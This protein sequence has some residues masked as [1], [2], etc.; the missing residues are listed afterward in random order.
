MIRQTT[1]RLFIT[2]TARGRNAWRTSGNQEWR[3]AKIQDPPYTDTLFNAKEV[4]PDSR[5]I[6][7]SLVNVCIFMLV[8]KDGLWNKP[9]RDQLRLCLAARVA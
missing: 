7:I 1:D 6:S 5:I 8:C 2:L 4:M 3:Q 9:L